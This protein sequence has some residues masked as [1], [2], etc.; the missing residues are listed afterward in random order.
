MLKAK[1]TTRRRARTMRS[2]WSRRS[3]ASSAVGSSGQS[4]RRALRRRR[5]E[6]QRGGHLLPKPLH[7]P[8]STAAEGRDLKSPIMPLHVNAVHPSDPSF[9]G[10]PNRGRIAASGRSHARSS[11]RSACC[12]SSTTGA[13]PRSHR[14][15][16]RFQR[17]HRRGIVC[18]RRLRREPSSPSARGGPSI[19][20]CD[21]GPWGRDIPRSCLLD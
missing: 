16:S 13:P 19:R 15:G 10:H 21:V 17:L 6:G 4:K 1:V 14:V 9:E 18:P 8:P 20:I 11:L 3:P 7:E 12:P 2:S 5:G